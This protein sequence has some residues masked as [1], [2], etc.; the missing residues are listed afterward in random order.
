M[1]LPAALV[2]SAVAAREAGDGAAARRLAMQ[3]LAADPSDRG[4]ISFLVDLLT[5]QSAYERSIAWLR[6]D[7][8]LVGRPARTIQF[9][10]FM[11]LHVGRLDEAGRLHA[12]LPQMARALPPGDEEAAVL[13]GLY[14]V[15]ERYRATAAE[16]AFAPGYRVFDEPDE[17][18]EVRLWRKALTYHAEGDDF[19]SLHH[20]VALDPLSGAPP[21]EHVVKADLD[22]LKARILS[23]RGIAGPP[24][25]SDSE[26]FLVIRSH[27]SGFCA[28]VIHVAVQLVAAELF[29]RTPLVYWGRESA[30]SAPE[31]D[32]LW[33]AFFDPIGPALDEIARRGGSCYPPFFTADALRKSNNRPWF[34]NAAGA[35]YLDILPR[36]E[37]VAVAERYC[38]L[39]D[40]LYLAPA[41]HPLRHRPPLDVF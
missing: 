15:V 29:G 7:L 36:R 37:E 8:A 25:V 5:Q 17:S 32:N 27:S 33:D 23:E 39:A 13:E 35:S 14:R 26:R 24:S 12:R 2:R 16:M 30:Y 1:T 38:F 22:R 3:A 6:R 20:L 19:A 18:R 9:L 31:I 10:L 41:D 4:A 34:H 21:L 28:D 40:L 11:L